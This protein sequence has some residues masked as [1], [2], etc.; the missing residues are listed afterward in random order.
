M[1]MG[2]IF[3]GGVRFEAR[4]RF[5][6]TR[7]LMLL[8]H[9]GHGS[10]RHWVANLDD[11]SADWDLLAPDLPGYGESADPPAD[12]G[13]PDL[14]AMLDRAL[15]SIVGGQRLRFVVGFSFGTLVATALTERW[16]REDRSPDALILVNPPLGREVSEEVVDIQRRAADL[17]R[18]QGLA[19]GIEMTLR[20]IMLSDPVRVTDELIQL[21]TRQARQTRFKSRPISRSIDLREHLRALSLP[22]FVIL[23][24]RDPHQ[25]RRISERVPQYRAMFGE[26]HVLILPGAHWLQY[27]RPAEFSAAL[28]QIVGRVQAPQPLRAVGSDR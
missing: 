28:R 10:W 13:L 3:A 9:G 24:E 1:T 22:R 6:G 25:R 19:A 12:A 23:G 7:P 21:G 5:D 20:R 4:G 17:A 27:D 15:P 26:D 16:Q 18:A 14:A 2:A 8:I 11:L